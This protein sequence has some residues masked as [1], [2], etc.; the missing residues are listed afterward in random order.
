[1]PNTTFEY[2]FSHIFLQTMKGTNLGE[3]DVIKSNGSTKR[4]GV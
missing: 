2:S 3:N 1:M 4:E